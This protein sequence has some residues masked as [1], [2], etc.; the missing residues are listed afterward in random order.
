MLCSSIRSLALF[1]TVFRSTN[2]PVPQKSTALAV[3]MFPPT[4]NKRP[5]SRIKHLC[6]SPFLSFFP[7]A[8]CSKKSFIPTMSS[9]TQNIAFSPLSPLSRFFA[10]AIAIIALIKTVYELLSLFFYMIKKELYAI[11]F[12]LLFCILYLITT[13]RATSLDDSVVLVEEVAGDF[14]MEEENELFYEPET[15]EGNEFEDAVQHLIPEAHM[16]LFL[17]HNWDNADHMDEQFIIDVQYLSDSAFDGDKEFDMSVPVSISNSFT[18]FVLVLTFFGFHRLLF[19]S[20]RRWSSSRMWRYVCTI[21][22]LFV[23]IIH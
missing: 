6:L 1:A 13:P 22:S 3:A 5:L 17:E 21:H 20:P 19:P 16:D 14:K 12:F 11:E 15:F 18:E 10:F 9:A 7:P 8:I 23:L 2:K 4:T